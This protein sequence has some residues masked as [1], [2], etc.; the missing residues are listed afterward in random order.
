MLYEV[1][2]RKEFVINVLEAK[3]ASFE[4][5]YNLDVRI[6]GMPYIRTLNAQNIVDEIGVFIAAALFVTVITSYSI[7]YT[8]L[9]EQS[10]SMKLKNQKQ[11]T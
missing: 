1:I 9:Y 10:T 3:V 8:K 2:T 6:S 5:K 4:Q 7:D 11:L